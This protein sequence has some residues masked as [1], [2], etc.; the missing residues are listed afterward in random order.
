M[1]NLRDHFS[2]HV[3]IPTS[4]V[5]HIVIYYPS[6]VYIGRDVYTAY[7]TWIVGAGEIRIGDEVMFGPYCVLAAG[8]QTF[9]NGSYRYD[10]ETQETISVGFGCWIG[11][12][13]VIHGG[14]NIGNSCL[15]GSN[16]VVRGGTIPENSICG[17]IPA[18]VLKVEE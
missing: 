7:G 2:G 4:W 13:V 10:L 15:I 11:A 14:A 8:S 3:G 6:M 16:S 17:G 9:K 5:H 18:R 1:G 12:H